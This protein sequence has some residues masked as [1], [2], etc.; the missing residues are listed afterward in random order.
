M[1]IR[2]VRGRS[3]SFG[4]R[5]TL[6]AYSGRLSSM[7]SKRGGTWGQVFGPDGRD[8]VTI[9]DRCSA[10]APVQ[11]VGSNVSCVAK[12]PETLR[13]LPNPRQ[14]SHSEKFLRVR[15]RVIGQKHWW[16]W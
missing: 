9:R 7:P 5:R 2:E 15:F 10:R 1:M 8:I 6:S 4:R 13:V 11:A 3:E 14:S 12:R 16:N